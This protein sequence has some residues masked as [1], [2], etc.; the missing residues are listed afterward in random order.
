M[1]RCV[2]LNLKSGYLEYFGNC[3]TYDYMWCGIALDRPCKSLELILV[4]KHN[5]IFKNV[6]YFECPESHGL[7]I[8]ADKLL[9]LRSNIAY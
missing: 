5:G 6:R 3:D 1:S 2:L 9:P 4:G 8:K 7:F